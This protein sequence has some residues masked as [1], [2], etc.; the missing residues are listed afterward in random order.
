MPVEEFVAVHS[1]LAGVIASLG[2]L[3]IAGLQ[4]AELRGLL[5]TQRQGRSVNL[6]LLAR[7][8]L[9]VG[10]DSL[11]LEWPILVDEGKHLIDLV[12]LDLVIIPL[13]LGQLGPLLASLARATLLP[14]VLVDLREVSIEESVSG[15]L[16]AALI[17]P[18]L[19][20][21]DI[22]LPQVLE[23]VSSFGRIVAQI[24]I[25]F[26]DLINLCRR[27]QLVGSLLGKRVLSRV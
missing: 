15:Y 4:F 3:K 21:L 1:A 8:P 19:R 20:K 23:E 9:L 14:G 24:L 7:F 6:E 11:D 27:L 10:A 2:Q 13:F 16:A 5:L 26:I 12:R 25:L 18:C 17:T 22:A